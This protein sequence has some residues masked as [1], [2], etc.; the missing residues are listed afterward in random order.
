MAKKEKIKKPKQIVFSEEIDSAINGYAIGLSFTG[1]S[2]RTLFTCLR[3]NSNTGS[4]C[5]TEI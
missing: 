2:K 3:W 4:S 1:K 5:M